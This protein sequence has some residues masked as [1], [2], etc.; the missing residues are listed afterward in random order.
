MANQIKT[1]V[2]VLG[3]GPGGYTAA[4]RAAD[5]GKKVVL[6]E[7][8][9]SLGGVCL[10]V[11]CIPSK[12]LLHIAKVVD[13]AHEMSEQGVTFGKPKLDN[14]KIVTWKNS[15]VSKLTGGLKALSKQRKVE[16]L[17]GVGKFSGTHQVTVTTKDGAVEVTFENAIIAV[18]SES[19]N[20]P[21]IPEDKR[22][23]SSTGALELADIKGSLL[24]LGGGIIGLEMA[25]VYSSLGVDVTVVE[26]MDQLIP[27]ADSDLVNVLQKRMQK[28][29]VKL[30]LK[31]KVTAVEAKKDGIYVSMEGDHATD[32][33]L[34]FQQV[35]VS[36]GRKP[37][38][39]MIDAEKAGVKVDERG[40]IKVDNQ[41]R[42]NVSHIFAI[43]DV[44][45]QPMLAHKAIPEGKIA[46]EVI[47]GKKHYFDPKCIASVA[48]TDPELAW[49]GLTEKEAKEKNI[50]YEKASFP[51]AASG[52]ALSMGRE[53]GMTKLLFCP[54]TKRIL[55]A[56]IVGVNA[57]DL[58]AETSLAIEMCC[59]VEDIALTIHPHPTLSETVAQAAEAFEGTIT[60]LYLP[61]K[62]KNI[63]G[64]S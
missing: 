1:D 35:L 43:G 17:T 7:R 49:T 63:D 26:F 8:Y 45:G 14:K 39:G 55:G 38:G 50:R 58:I 21:F 47:A 40:F 13:E 30:L 22:I 57:G 52:R 10:N 27:G 9:D 61:K 42:T 20:L 36:V 11:G 25:T 23:F 31:T 53:E 64:A 3:S 33:P 18:G 24:V 29:G 15:V 5:L 54:D 56:G 19:I 4:F 46:A 12:A 62:K 32:K 34:C 16:V 6:V 59:D 44:V 41:Q 37:N 60:D 48:Y 51:W 2:I 28:K